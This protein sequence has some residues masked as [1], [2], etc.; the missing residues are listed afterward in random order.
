MSTDDKRIPDYINAT[1]RM[2]GGDYDVHLDTQQQPEDDV[3]RLGSN[4][5][6][7]ANV[8]DTKVQELQHI[9][10]LTAKINAGMLLPD[11]LEMIYNEFHSLIP[12]DRI[13]FSI[14]EYEDNEPWVCAYWSRT[15]EKDVQIREGYRARLHGSSLEQIVETLEPRII[16]DLEVYYANKPESESTKRILRE[17][18]RS[19]MTCPLV[20]NGNPV[21]FIF[22]SS[23][24]PHAYKPSHI[25]TF[26]QIAGQLA[27][28]VEKGW[29]ISEL[30]QQQAAIEE[31]N[32]EL[33]RLHRTKNNFLGMAAHD[34]R[35]PIGNIQSVA[36]MLV[37][38]DWAFSE[39]ERDHFLRGVIRQTRYMLAILDDLLDITQIESGTFQ[40]RQVIVDVK[41]LLHEVVARHQH[42]GAS[43]GSRVE[44]LSWGKGEL[45]AD[46]IR[47]TQ[48]LDNLISNAL[49]YSPPESHITVSCNRREKDWYFEV[50]D[51]GP[52]IDPDEAD[53][54]FKEFTK[55]SAQPTGDEPSTGLGLSITR[56][57]VHAQKGEIGFFNHDNGDSGATFWFT[58][59]AGADESA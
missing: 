8:L 44:L 5:Q 43:K 47:L 58:L 59:P 52:G 48:I 35:N 41:E 25:T 1:K 39:D 50:S 19:S 20:V 51:Q 7:L 56:R 55:L 36:E 23:N 9:Q 11:I 13:G 18:V 26:R 42:I 30:A 34:L 37:D 49:K 14:I 46:P 53:K 31:Q 22:F 40:V 57:M 28:I 12:Y 16:N 45:L 29:F 2:I 15:E 33:R 38:P 6:N 54:V 4:L 24:Q 17:G 32:A 3:S 10:R 27:I 21:G